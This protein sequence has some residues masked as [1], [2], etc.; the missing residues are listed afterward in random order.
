MQMI[1]YIFFLLSLKTLQVHAFEP[2][3]AQ[4]PCL[5]CE[6]MLKSD[7]ESLQKLNTAIICNQKFSTQWSHKTEATAWTKTLCESLANEGANLFKVK[8]KD[9]K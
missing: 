5:N 3:E 6:Q 9:I 1:T 4:G 2:T 8:I 7:F